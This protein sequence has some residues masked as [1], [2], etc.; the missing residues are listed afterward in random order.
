MWR[1]FAD[2]VQNR[3]VGESGRRDTGGWRATLEGIDTQRLDAYLERIGASRLA[4]PNAD[5][6]HDLQRRHLLT[7][8][9]ENLSI[10]LGEPIAL[11]EDAMFE[12]VVERRRGGFCYEL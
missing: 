1:F 3:D 8:P 5:A 10:H 4:R 6:L 2:E 9:F 7:V 11:D 12:K